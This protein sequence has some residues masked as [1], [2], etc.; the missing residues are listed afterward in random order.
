M[1]EKSQLPEPLSP[2]ASQLSWTSTSAVGTTTRRNESSPAGGASSNRTVALTQ[3]QCLIP[4]ANA[5]RPLT[6]YPPGTGRAVPE[7]IN[8][9]A[10]TGARPP[11]NTISR[12]SS[13]SQAAGS[14]V[15]WD[16]IITDHAAEASTWA[17]ASITSI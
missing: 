2:T 10:A 11:P 7:G 17:S 4:L 16:P 15:D 14:P 9:P 12:A 3:S 8:D 1:I 6:R 5:H 13:D